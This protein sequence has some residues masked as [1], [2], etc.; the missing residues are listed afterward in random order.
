[1]GTGAENW[2][3]GLDVGLRAQSPACLA[4]FAGIGT[5]SGGNTKRM[6][7]TGAGIDNDSSVD[8]MGKRKDD[9]N[10][11][12]SIYAEVGVHFCINCSTRLTASAQYHV[13]TEER[14]ADFRF[15]GFS[16]SFLN[17]VKCWEPLEK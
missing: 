13:T 16:L 14:D 11:A 5:F 7:V 2:F 3:A 15:F 10:F 17:E 12:A 4:P 8:E 1:M 9:L 6:R